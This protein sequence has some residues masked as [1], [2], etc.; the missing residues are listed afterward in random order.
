[1][2]QIRTNAPLE[3][4][5]RGQGRTP[6]LTQSQLA[7]GFESFE[8][9]LLIVSSSSKRTFKRPEHCEYFPTSAPPVARI[10]LRTYVPLRDTANS[11]WN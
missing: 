11:L 8:S 2:S 7:E 9:P 10:L 4:V 3:I 6:T 1:M 5:E